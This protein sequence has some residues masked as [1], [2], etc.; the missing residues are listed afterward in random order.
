MNVRH[1]VFLI[2]LMPAVA[3]AQAPYISQPNGRFEVNEVRGCAPFLVTITNTDLTAVQCNGNCSITW[4]DGTGNH[5]SEGIFS[6]S[7]AN[8]GRYRLQI[9]YDGGQGPDEIEIVVTPSI[10]PAFEV[11]HCSGNDL[12]V[13]VTDTNYDSYIIDFNGTAVEV[14]RG[15][16]PVTQ[17]MAS[18]NIRVRGKN[19]N[20]ADNCAVSNPLPITFPVPNIAPVITQLVVAGNSTIDLEM[21]TQQNFLYRLEVSSNGGSFQNAG[22]LV[23]V[24][25]RTVTSLNT[26]NNY[27]CFRLGKVN[28][29]SGDIVYSPVICS[30]ILTATA[31]N[32]ANSLSWTTS[33]AGVNNFT[34]VR[35]GTP[36]TPTTTLTTFSDINIV[37]GTEYLYQVISNYPTGRS[38]SAIRNV[39]AISNT[40]PDPVNEIS[41]VVNGNEVQLTWQESTT[42]NADVYTVYRQA[43]GGPLNQLQ[44]GIAVP[45]YTDENYS[46]SNSYCYRVQY[47]DVCGN[48][49]STVAPVCPIVLSYTTNSDNEIILSWDSYNGWSSGVLR[50]ELYKYDLQ[51]NPI[52]P[53]RNMN[54]V[55][56]FTDNDLTD[57]GYY[58]VVRAIPVDTDNNQSVSN[59][60][61]AIRNLRFAYPK[62][63][64]PDNQG[65]V[66]NETFRVF[67]TEEFIDHFEMKIFNRWG[68]MI[69]SSSDLLK[70]WDGKFNGTAQPEGTYTFIATL[71]DKAGR[72]YKRDGAVM[73]LRKK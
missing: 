38:F 8:P 14:A 1:V 54:L 15:S 23:N 43:S 48:T 49:S 27:Y 4:G 36:L 34:V 64:T 20:A 53:A 35:N 5:A 52:G 25:T 73:L 59:E 63:F 67:V 29:C 18:G 28:P 51:H 71:R 68:E 58:Y 40:I 26:N 31:Q 21:T 11:Y 30:A 13:R 57:Q 66:A 17:T 65:P 6:H 45:H 47:V 24:N 50:Y 16:A 3:W 60:V 69:F 37:C 44:N 62:A 72:T 41:S 55:T 7:Y 39:T 22:S 70:G 46:S 33:T 12:Q 32:N 2:L 61:M 42:F 56:T 19:N 9:N 10:Q